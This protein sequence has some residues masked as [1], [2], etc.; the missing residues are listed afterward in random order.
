VKRKPATGRSSACGKST[1]YPDDVEYIKADFATFNMIKSSFFYHFNKNH[2]T[3]N[4]V[5]SEWESL[6]TNTH[7]R[8]ALWRKGSTLIAQYDKLK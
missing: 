4:R 3:E 7:P 2:F 5:A 1:G 8:G 6:D